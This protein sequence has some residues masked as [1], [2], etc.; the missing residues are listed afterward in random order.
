MMAGMEKK[1]EER[2]RELFFKNSENFQ[3][4]VFAAKIFFLQDDPLL[5]IVYI[6]VVFKVIMPVTATCD[7]HYCTFLGHLGCCDRDMIISIS[8]ALPRWP[9]QVQVRHHCV[10]LSLALSRYLC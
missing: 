1:G 3:N 10:S 9:R 6:G 8:V 5:W 2:L 7:S 4:E